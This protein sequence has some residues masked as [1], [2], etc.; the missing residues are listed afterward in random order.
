MRHRKA[1][2]IDF[3]TLAVSRRTDREMDT[4]EALIAFSPDGNRFV[5]SRQDGTLR[6]WDVATGRVVGSIKGP[7][8]VVIPMGQPRWIF[9]R[10][11]AFPPGGI[12]VVSGGMRGWN[13]VDPVTNRIVPDPVTGEFLRVEPLQVWDAEFDPAH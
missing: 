7:E 10:A 9:A 6:I 5:S 11:V 4:S 12:R 3:A 8:P 13:E 1:A 2:I